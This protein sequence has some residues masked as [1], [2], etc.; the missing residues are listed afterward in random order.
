MRPTLL[1]GFLA[2]LVAVAISAPAGADGSGKVSVQPDGPKVK[3]RAP[4]GTHMNPAFPWKITDSGDSK[5]KLK[6]KSDFSFDSGEQPGWAEVAPA[7]G[8]LTGGYCDNS[9][10]G[11][12]TFTATCTSSSCTVN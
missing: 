9:G 6:S 11:C 12:H 7:A 2:A 10:G 5:K 1:V 4:S 3:F 8:T